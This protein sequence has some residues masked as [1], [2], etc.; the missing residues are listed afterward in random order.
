MGV[1][2]G[3]DEALDNRI[4]THVLAGSEKVDREFQQIFYYMKRFPAVKEHLLKELALVIKPM[5]GNRELKK[6]A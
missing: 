2:I 1:I 3:S 6:S 4:E 5:V